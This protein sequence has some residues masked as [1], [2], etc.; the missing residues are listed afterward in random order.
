MKKALALFL[1]L[2]LLASFGLS[3]AYNLS[4][5]PWNIATSRNGLL[6]VGFDSDNLWILSPFCNHEDVFLI[7]L[8]SDEQGW[9][10]FSDG[11]HHFGEFAI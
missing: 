5:E 1:A 10:T 11:L 6:L 8:G 9:Y 3:A 7:G 2:Y 4:L